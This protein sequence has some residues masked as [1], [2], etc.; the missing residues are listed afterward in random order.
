MLFAIVVCAILLPRNVVVDAHGAPPAAVSCSN[1]LRGDNATFTECCQVTLGNGNDVGISWSLDT[2]ANTIEIEFKG[3]SNG[4]LSFGFAASSA[5]MDGTDAVIAYLNSG[6]TVGGIGAYDLSGN[7]SPNL[8]TDAKSGY[9]IGTPTITHVN[10]IISG[11][12]KRAL[13]VT[14]GVDAVASGSN[15]VNIAY[16]SSQGSNGAN[17]LQEHVSK[18]SGTIDFTIGCD[19]TDIK[20]SDRWQPIY[21]GCAVLLAVGLLF[22]IAAKCGLCVSAVRSVQGY[23]LLPPKTLELP[24]TLDNWT[25]NIWSSFKNLGVGELAI[26][27]GL[28]VIGALFYAETRDTYGMDKAMAWGWINIVVLAAIVVPVTR[29]SLLLRFFGVPFERAI[30]YHR[31]LGRTFLLTQIAHAITLLDLY[32][33][34][35]MLDYDRANVRGIYGGAAFFLTVLIGV[36]AIEPVRRSLWEMFYF[37]HVLL[38]PA[39]YAMSLLHVKKT[40]ARVVLLVP[41]CLYGLDVLL[42]AA[43]VMYRSCCGGGSADARVKVLDDLATRIEIDVKLPCGFEAGQYCW[44]N[45]PAVSMLEWH[46]FSISCA[47]SSTK[48]SKDGTTTLTFHCGDIHADDSFTNK[49]L[50]AAKGSAQL[51]VHMDGPH[52]KC[53]LDNLDSFEGVLL[54]A[55][56]MGITP[57]IS[58][59]QELMCRKNAGTASRLKRCHL[60]YSSRWIEQ[61]QWFRSVLD[62][63]TSVDGFTFSLY[64][65]GSGEDDKSIPTGVRRGRPNIPSIVTRFDSSTSADVELATVGASSNSSKTVDTIDDGGN[66]EDAAVLAC[67]PALLVADAQD[68]AWRSGFCFHKESFLL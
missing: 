22:V 38:V 13:D 25:L 45:V 17:Q 11:R 54:I 41:L 1:E 43:F 57:M 33:L 20:D 59:F 16:H 51:R 21:A 58:I 27:V 7:D 2:S 31:M 18:F 55:G 34:D 36:T 52:G 37:S 19:I 44:L 68:A 40:N 61:L 47:P 49:L 28:A 32:S 4:Y 50:N 6:G 23:T 26:A 46:P 67:G 10:G 14:T 8:A 35:E 29:G 60:V 66:L 9:F 48:I 65:T 5:I 30:R 12:F 56:G 42:R 63:S 24:T 64:W 39:I 15:N 53:G 3:S 62:K